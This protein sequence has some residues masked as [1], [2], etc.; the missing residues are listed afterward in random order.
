MANHGEVVG[1]EEVGEA[2]VALQRVEQVDHLRADRDVE[3]GDGLVEHEQLRVQR[4]RTR[5]P[6]PLPLA[7]ENS[8]GKRLPCSG[9]G[10]RC[11]A[12]PR[13]CPPPLACRGR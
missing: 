4:K 8:C 12:A 6:D 3:G 5:D 9:E 2:E 1:D 10:R 13:S 11:A 7:P